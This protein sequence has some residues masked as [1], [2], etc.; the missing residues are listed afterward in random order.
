MSDKKLVR[1]LVIKLSALGDFVLALGPFA[2]I[3]AHH[4]GDPVT[5]LTTAPFAAMARASGYFDEVWVDQRPKAHEVVKCVLLAQRLRAGHF[6]RVY[7]LQRTDRSNTYFR[8]LKMGRRLEWNG[9]APGCT[10]RYDDPAQH[11]IHTIERQKAQLAVAGIETVP[12]ADLS[13]LSADIG[14]FGLPERFALLVPGSAAHRPEKRWPAA[15]QA[16]L[17]NALAGQGI[18]PVLLGAAAE[19]ETLAQVARLCAEARNLC[20]ETGFDDIAAL[21][22]RATLA[23]GNDT[24]PMHLIAAAGCP[25]LVLFS[26]ASDPELTAPRGKRVEILRRERLADLAVADVQE[27]LASLLDDAP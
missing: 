5:L 6:D 9:I 17:A 20:G 21:A 26:A 4:A 2:A 15:A 24:G 11:R 8:V 7:D 18:A 13:W 1:V 23:I 16:E 19:A 25:A 10:Q 27:A 12:E 3:R 22:R 14:R